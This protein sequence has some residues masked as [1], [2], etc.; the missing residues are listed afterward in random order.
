MEWNDRSY[1]GCG[2]CPVDIQDCDRGLG[3]ILK[4]TDGGGDV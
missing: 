2:G 1:E 4:N 3:E